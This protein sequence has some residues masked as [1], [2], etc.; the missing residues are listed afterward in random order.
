MTYNATSEALCGLQGTQWQKY[1]QKYLHWAWPVSPTTVHP[2]STH[3]PKGLG[4]GAGR[5]CG[6][7]HNLFFFKTE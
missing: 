2:P 7:T 3:P 4:A 6:T 1:P 5:H